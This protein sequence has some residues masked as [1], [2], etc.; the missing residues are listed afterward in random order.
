MEPIQVI[1]RSDNDNFIPILEPQF[2]VL[3]MINEYLG[4]RAIEDGSTVE[5][6]YADERPLADL[7]AKY[8]ILYGTRLHIDSAEVS[9]VDAPT[10]HSCVES[11]RMNAHINA[12]YKFEFEIDRFITMPDGEKHRIADIALTIEG[13]PRK[14]SML[15]RSSEMNSRFSY[16]YGAMLR[17]GREGLVIKMANAS[18]KI[19]LI[20]RLLGELDVEWVGHKYTVGLVPTCHEVTFGADGK[21]TKFL[22]LALVERAEA[23]ARAASC[24]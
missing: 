17:F 4:R 8:L 10:G 2:V 14:T 20:K 24:G 23:F 1:Q 9:V 19:E 3:G 12:L 15:Y 16:L 21:L 22:Q 6:F 18:Q 5:L 13:F 11:R 7:F